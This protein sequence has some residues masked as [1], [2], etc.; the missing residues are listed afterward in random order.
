MYNKPVLQVGA[1][2]GDLLFILSLSS[3]LICLPGNIL[4]YFLR[5]VY[6]DVM[7]VKLW[8]LVVLLGKVAGAGI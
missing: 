7:M 8:C 1:E 2:V 6:N 3:E 4:L 5:Q